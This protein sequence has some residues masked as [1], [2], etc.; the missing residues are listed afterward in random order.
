V[1]SPADC[2]EGV[3]GL[4]AGRVGNQDPHR[5]LDLRRLGVA[6][7]RRRGEK[8]EREDGDE[9]SAW[10]RARH[11]PPPPP[12]PM[13][14][15]GASGAAAGSY[16]ATRAAAAKIAGHIEGGGERIRNDIERDQN[17]DAFHG[18]SDL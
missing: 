7:N 16:L 5:D 9:K 13:N 3:L 18:Q 2:R 15:I 11:R 6:V 12:D 14:Q 17:A 4:G 8:R 1:V 10:R